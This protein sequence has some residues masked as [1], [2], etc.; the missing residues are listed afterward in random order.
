MRE[1][2][3]AGE[4]AVIGLARSG[5][6]AARLAAREGARV[7]ASDS[8]PRPSNSVA[9]GRGA[10]A[11]PDALA[12]LGITEQYGGHD[13]ERI[14]KASLAIVSPGVPPDA[15]PVV[16][17]RGAGI[18][19]VSEVELALWFLGKA[20]LI[21]VTGT[22]GK[23]TVTALIAHLLRSLG[24]DATAAGNIGVALSEIALMPV[25][26]VWIALE[27]SS[28]QLHDT[29]S[30]RPAV[31]VL[32]NLSPDHL[33][34][35]AGTDDYYADKDR[36]FVNADAA[37]IW[38][39]N[40]DDVEVTR[41]AARVRGE[42]RRFSVRGLGVDATFDEAHEAI[43]LLGERL[44]PRADIPLFGQHNVANVLAATLAVAS[45]DPAFTTGSARDGLARGLRSFEGL[46]N[47]LEVVADSEGVLWINDSKAT[48]V[49]SARVAIDAMTRPTVILMG[50]KHKGESYTSLAASLANRARL[51]IVFGEAAAQI[52]ADLAAS[53]THVPLERLGSS[54]EEVIARARTAA[55]RGDAVLLSPACSSFDMFRNYEDRG[56]IFRRLARG[57]A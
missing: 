26:P 47:R 41:R 11:A 53:G 22:N 14:A 48:N 20:R 38:V 16:A 15:A 43:T 2:L 3:A 35:Y 29:S 6:A 7:Y 33:D 19:V 4:V 23:S 34:R 24:A 28:F 42:H 52:E 21:A 51:V 50:G 17:A 8:G 32:T 1:L 30:L 39:T 10:A 45:A 18:P 46:P 54:F 40:A 9:T 25:P 44:M 27:M 56:D 13:L 12:V 55:A 5:L 36:L 31:G 57:V 49:A 37:S